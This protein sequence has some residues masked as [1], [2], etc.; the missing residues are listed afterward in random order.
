MA[1]VNRGFQIKLPKPL[2]LVL[3]GVLVIVGAGI[4]LKDPEQLLKLLPGRDLVLDSTRILES[5]SEDLK[6]YLKSALLRSMADSGAEQ[7]DYD[8]LG[9]I[10]IIEL[11]AEPR[12]HYRNEREFWLNSDRRTVEFTARFRSGERE[13]T[14][15]GTFLVEGKRGR[16]VLV[17][18]EL[19]DAP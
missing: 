14:A 12:G 1:Q 9:S 10:H 6:V 4:A 15:A 19:L 17:N 18:A 2:A 13:H 5:S 11:K 7:S 8:S 16:I 3:A